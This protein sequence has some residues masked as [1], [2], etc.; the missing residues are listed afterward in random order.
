MSDLR[1]SF[2]HPENET[3]KTIIVRSMTATD[4]NEIMGLNPQS[5]AGD[6]F[7]LFKAYYADH[8]GHS[9]V[10]VEP[11]TK[12]HPGGLI[13]G[14]SLLKK[15]SVLFGGKI[16]IK[17]IFV[18]PNCE[19]AD[20]VANSLIEK[21]AR[22]CLANGQDKMSVVVVE[23]DPVKLDICNRFD[24]ALTMAAPYCDIYSVTDLSGKFGYGA[25]KKAQAKLTP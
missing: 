22:V 21:S 1:Q 20:K 7:N 25:E 17:D 3:P 12:N 13:L 4:I 18:H 2:D 14:Y 16:G 6:K 23:N 24:A 8:L 19:N 9:L 11:R 15:E 5:H 10:A